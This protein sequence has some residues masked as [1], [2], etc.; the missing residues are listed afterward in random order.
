MDDIIL[1]KDIESYYY[2]T[3]NEC[4]LPF[5][6]YP[7]F[8]DIVAFLPCSKPTFYEFFP[9]ESNELNDLKELLERNK[10]NKKVEIRTKLFKS[11]KAAELL[12]LYRLICTKEEQQ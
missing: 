10:V 7:F 3:T 12:A 1:G 8:D 11:D 5:I 9:V 2:D 6:S 4:L